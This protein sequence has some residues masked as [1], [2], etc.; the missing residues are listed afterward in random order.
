[1]S[2]LPSRIATGLL[3]LFALCVVPGGALW[4]ASPLGIFLA[5]ARLTS[6][7]E[8]F[9]MLFPSAP[10]LLGAGVIG[11]WA[12]GFLGGGWLTRF[13]IVAALAGLALVIAGIAGQFWLSLDETY[14][15]AAPAYRTFRL[16][17]IVSGVGAVL[18]GVSGIR[19]RTLPLW[20]A[21]T[22]IVAAL[23]GL[24]AFAW[25]LGTAGSGLWAVF[26]AG[27]VWLGFSVAASKLAALL[28]SRWSPRRS[29]KAG[30]DSA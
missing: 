17:L 10:L 25:E 2:K 8:V 21:L 13:S 29:G 27:W 30:A 9:W 14:T 12:V 7:D 22:F 3:W 11:L 16:G 23:C 24:V 26:G 5:N 20:G 15:I 4:M 1:M 28:Q 6:G 19:A 18:V